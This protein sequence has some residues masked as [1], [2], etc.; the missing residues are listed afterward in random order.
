M[1]GAAIVIRA[2]R[3][4]A[5][6]RKRRA[7]RDYFGLSRTICSRKFNIALENSRTFTNR[8]TLAG[9][10]ERVAAAKVRDRIF[11]V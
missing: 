9:A 3:G 6:I 11:G 10:A 2:A 1:R 4:H 5:R 7:D 8:E